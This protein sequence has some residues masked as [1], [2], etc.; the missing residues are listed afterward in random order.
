MALVGRE[1]ELAELAEALQR[2]AQGESGRVVLAGPAGIG[3]SCLL[4]ESETRLDDVPGLI[5]ARGHATE[6]QAGLPY[7]VLAEALE[8][9]LAALPDERFRATVAPAAH[10]LAALLPSL[11][12]RLDALGIAR[13]A[14][15][16]EAAEQVGSRV[17]ESIRRTLERI[18]ATGV[19]LLILEDLHWSDP[20]TRHL[21]ESLQGVARP[22]SLCLLVTFQPDELHRRHPARDF[23]SGL[24]RAPGAHVIQPAPLSGVELAEL[25]HALEGERPSGS[26]LAALS[27]G[28]GGNPLLAV[29][30]ITARRALAGLRLSDPFDEVL[31]A[32]LDALSPGA[33]RSVRLL[34][35][36]RR[37]LPRATCLGLALPEG[38]LSGSAVNEAIDSGLLVERAGRTG[39]GIAHELYAEGIEALCLPPE[40]H[41]FHAALAGSA[42]LPSAEAAWH[43]AAASRTVAARAS[44]LA[45]GLAAE[46]LDPGET[47][48]LHYQSALELGDPL[49][50]GS[51]R[52][53]D[54]AAT[55]AAAARA[56]A[57]GGSFRRAAA[58]IRRAIDSRPRRQRTSPRTG[59]IRE[60]ALTDAQRQARR[61]DSL[62][63]AELYTQ[64]GRYR[65]DG[66]DLVGG[67]AA[68]HEALEMMPAEPSPGRARALAVL[69]QHLMIDGR[70]QESAALAREARAVAARTEPPALPEAG[71]ATCTLGVDTAYL[72]E[73]D[74]GLAL[75]EEA[76]DVA[77]RTGRL[78]DL[79]RAYANRT[80]LLDLDSRREA[81][82]A[83]VNKGIRDARDAGLGDTYGAFLRGNAADI[84]FM[85]G[86]WEESE[87]ECRAGLAGRPAGVAWFSPIL[88][89]GL[90]LV[91]SRA[92][93]EATRLVGRTLLQLEQVPAGQWTALV[94]R[95]AVSLLLWRGQ[96]DEAVTV[97]T[98]AWDRV[99]ETGDAGQIALAAST[100]LEAAA[101]LTEV[102]RQARDYPAVARA[103]GLAGRALPDSERAVAASA[104]P[105]TLGARREA[106]LHLETARAQ[107]ARL[108][109]RP[110]AARWAR[111]A[112]GWAAVPVP[113]QVAKARWWQALALLQAG[114]GREP[115][116]RPLQEAWQIASELPAQ[117]LRRALADLARRARIDLPGASGLARPAPPSTR[118]VPD[119]AVDE[120]PFLPRGIGERQMLSVSPGPAASDRSTT[121]RAIGQ[122]LGSPEGTNGLGRFG[123]S[124]R[125]LEVL[126]VLTEGRSNREIGE[127]LFISDRTVGVHV[128]R[129]LAKLGVSGRVEAAGIAIRSGMLPGP[130]ADGPTGTPAGAGEPTGADQP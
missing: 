76:T 52:A 103:G 15:S 63:L 113:Y 116:R 35:A 119:R 10:D 1:Q 56:A 13:E 86:R 32:R 7:A 69:A 43:W 101:T 97:A 85:L 125:E 39:L 129:I 91:E 121:A 57:V 62:R 120:G 53:V 40:R 99:M 115:A 59:S 37:P 74:R 111:V 73:P 127:R 77:R 38:H 28:S 95:T 124:P 33:L 68:L 66:G 55:L 60:A 90:V 20:A 5:V 12:P 18:A 54:L 92:D 45:A 49:G 22:S 44:H 117:P 11:V 48:L 72:G 2:A 130:D 8:G 100:C 106:E 25:C 81:A 3:I 93:E 88:Y 80:T 122:R 41:A 89:L 112:D 47:A 109:G 96:A 50:E 64:L 79:M 82:L 46:R 105:P 16:L 83:V 87:V 29:Q 94:L 61:D 26:S 126:W 58:L 118:I 19:L 107:L 42:E 24:M 23:L 102:G 27:E 65:W 17:A 67:I 98:A 9:A 114:E 108:R 36:A 31:G 30:L 71:H 6:P 51:D 110:S 75:L 21:I 128:R 70:F 14:P 4:D 104:L 78:D 84:L 34:A 123:L